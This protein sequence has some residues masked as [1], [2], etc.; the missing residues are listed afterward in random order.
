MRTKGFTGGLTGRLDELRPD[1]HLH[2]HALLLQSQRHLAPLQLQ[3]QRER[4][5]GPASS[6]GA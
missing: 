6:M 5:S 2:R 4:G 1:G 3:A